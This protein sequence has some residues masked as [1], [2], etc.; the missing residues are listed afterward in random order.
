MYVY[1][2]K[3]YDEY[4]EYLGETIDP[5]TLLRNYSGTGVFSWNITEGADTVIKIAER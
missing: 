3:A 2:L 5:V 1:D 4:T